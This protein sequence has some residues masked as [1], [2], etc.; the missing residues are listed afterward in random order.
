[1]TRREAKRDEPNPRLEEHY[2]SA[3]AHNPRIRD[4]Y[5]N[6]PPQQVK[7]AAPQAPANLVVVKA[8]NKHVVLSV[9]DVLRGPSEGQAFHLARQSRW[10]QAKLTLCGK[11]VARPLEQFDPSEATC[12]EC[13]R[14][15][16][17]R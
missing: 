15:A 7:R 1:M 16:G 17:I 12:K 14:Y 4:Y 13:L 8:W 5:L 6:P 9:R 11:R 3:V 2:Q 10:P